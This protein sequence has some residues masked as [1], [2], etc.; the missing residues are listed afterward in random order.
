M[1]IS[2]E[3]RRDIITAW[4]LLVLALMLFSY[5]IYTATALPSLIA[6]VALAWSLVCCFRFETVT[7]GRIDGQFVWL[8]GVSPK[9]LERLGEF[10]G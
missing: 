4:L 8:N 1:D 7:V 3:R 5:S 9:F 2:R 6:L 10:P